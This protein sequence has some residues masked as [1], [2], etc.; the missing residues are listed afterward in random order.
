MVLNSTASSSKTLIQMN[1]NQSMS[2]KNKTE[3]AHDFVFGGA[4]VF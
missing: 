3:I 1:K 4:A 2:Q